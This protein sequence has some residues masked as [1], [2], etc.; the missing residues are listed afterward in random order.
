M[1]I[2]NNAPLTLELAKNEKLIN[3]SFS[4]WQFDANNKQESRRAD[5]R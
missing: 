2:Q 5:L 3:R 1:R 4:L